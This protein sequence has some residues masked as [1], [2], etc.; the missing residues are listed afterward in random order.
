MVM[1]N[2][3]PPRVYAEKKRLPLG[4]GTWFWVDFAGDGRCVR[5]SAITTVDEP[6]KKLVMVPI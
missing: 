3:S 6:F 4:Q 1:Q 5:I 2:E